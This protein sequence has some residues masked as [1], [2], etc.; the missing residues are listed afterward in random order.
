MD[1][2]LAKDNNLRKAAVY[3]LI[4]VIY[5]QNIEDLEKFWHEYQLKYVG[6][7]D[8]I[9]YLKNRWMDN[10]EMWWHGNRRRSPN[11]EA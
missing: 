9:S 11:F 8:W 2:I 5:G 10:P 7:Q 1:H 3:D 6:H 4:L